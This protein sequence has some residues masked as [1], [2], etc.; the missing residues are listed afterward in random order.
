M[1]T[2][3]SFSC[4]IISILSL[5]GL[6]LAV[7]YIAYIVYGIIFLVNDYNT[8]Y[9]CAGSSL[10]AYVLTAVIMAFLR[11]SNAKSANETRSQGGSLCCTMVCMVIIEYGLAI[12][13]GIELFEKTCPGLKETELWTYGL[14]TFS[15]QV[16][17]GTFA[18]VVPLVVMCISFCCD[19][20]ETNNL[21]T[22]LAPTTLA[23]PSV[24]TEQRPIQLLKKE[25]NT[26]IRDIE[27][28]TPPSV[29]V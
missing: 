1:S 13:G 26:N 28:A 9:D 23:P 5:L 3:D 16:S 14:V 10:W 27:S 29:G 19:K 24:S 25:Y 8:S 17:C 15:I 12:W 7:G 18:V 2:E 11:L 4:C 20:K 22:N 6:G 21:G